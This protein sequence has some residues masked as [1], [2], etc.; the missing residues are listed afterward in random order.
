MGLRLMIFVMTFVLMLVNEPDLQLCSLLSFVNVDSL[1]A[2]AGKGSMVYLC[3]VSLQEEG[4][5]D[6][7]LKVTQLAPE[8][9]DSNVHF[10]NNPLSIYAAPIRL[11]QSMQVTKDRGPERWGMQMKAVITALHSLI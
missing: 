8:V 11:F 2:S 4:G 10:I 5:R 6:W 9:L 3:F 7:F 1:T